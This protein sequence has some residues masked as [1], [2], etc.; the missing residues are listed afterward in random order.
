MKHLEEKGCTYLPHFRR[1]IVFSFYF[2][3]ATLRLF[4]HAFYP[5]LFQDTVAWLQERLP[6]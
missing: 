5:D 4:V 6:E 1:A 2:G 3:V